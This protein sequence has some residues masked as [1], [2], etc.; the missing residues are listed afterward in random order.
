MEPNNTSTLPDTADYRNSNTA[1]FTHYDGNV[2]L[3][4][5]I[6]FSIANVGILNNLSFI[7]VVCKIR[8]LQT[9]TNA[10][11]VNL[12]LSDMTWL[13]NVFCS[14]FV[15]IPC[16]VNALSQFTPLIESCLTVAVI[17]VERYIA[18][19]HPFKAYVMT[20][21]NMAI[22]VSITW[23]LSVALSST[24]VGT[25]ID[26]L[27]AEGQDVYAIVCLCLIAAVLFAC[28]I[29]TSSLYAL[30]ACAMQRRKKSSM[31]TLHKVAFKETKQVLRT[32]VIT[33]VVIFVSII[34]SVVLFF[35]VVLQKDGVY[36]PTSPR[37]DTFYVFA[38]TA[39]ILYTLNCSINP[40]IYKLCNSTYRNAV[41]S[42]Y[43][44]HFCAPRS[45]P[46]HPQVQDTAV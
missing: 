2:K 23:I 46:V 26:F 7:F 10:L 8:E 37:I 38:Q 44:P 5:V 11:L 31:L 12:A 28:V 9:K 16:T 18:I 29:L 14:F 40:F 39:K 32:V 15:A 17:S 20:S 21:K 42:T 22:A 24:E 25:C 6:E 41:K 30:I 34:P 27:D 35:I 45:G 1:N 33:N 3:I 43:C 13:M 19:C 36:R 4:Q